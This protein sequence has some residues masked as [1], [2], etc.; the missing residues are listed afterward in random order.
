MGL[1]HGKF[2]GSVSRFQNACLFVCLL[3]GRSQQEG[4][5]HRCWLRVQLRNELVSDV[6]DTMSGATESYTQQARGKKKRRAGLVQLVAAILLLWF[7]F[8]VSLFS[9]PFCG[10][11]S[12]LLKKRQNGVLACTISAPSYRFHRASEGR[13]RDSLPRRRRAKKAQFSL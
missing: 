10:A 2:G 3:K 11:G 7:C 12:L 5:L 8:L 1:S 4:V 13:A 6:S 9:G